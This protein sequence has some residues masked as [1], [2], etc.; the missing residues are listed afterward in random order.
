MTILHFFTGCAA[1]AGLVLGLALPA[2]GQTVAITGGR[3]YPVARPP[4]DGATV[5]IV[6]G[7]ITAVGKA[8]TP[9]AGARVIDAKGR[10]VTPGLINGATRLGLIEVGSVPS[11]NDATPRGDHG[12]AAAFRAWD[13][14]NPDSAMWVP[15]ASEGIT[16]VVSLPSGRFI[17]GQGAVVDTGGASRA[18]QLRLGPA[19]MVANLEAPALAETQAR[20]E[21]L[22]R[23]RELLDDSRDFAARKSDYERAATRTYAAGRLQLQALQLVLS[24]KLPLLVSANRAAD[25]ENALDISQQYK[26]RL[27]ILGGAEAW[28]VAGKLAAAKVAVLTTA[29]DSIP[30]TFDTLGARQE[31]AAIL[32]KAGVS[33]AIIAD[34]GETFNVRNIR[35]HAG[36]A[37]AFGLS[38]EDALRAVT[39]APA[40]VFGVA[41]SIGTIDVGKDANLVVWDGDP[42][43]FATQAERV[44]IRGVEQLGTSRQDLLTERYKMPGKR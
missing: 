26:V 31:N 18:E 15:A 41:E 2:A 7:K 28:Q 5:V 40:E 4:I 22:M 21:L 24:G 1:S 30:S 39:L 23:L 3:V 8:V 38:W 37:V 34:E 42:F 43:E 32:R 19:V 20:G 11:T 13:G 25:I 9:P 33:V 17:S 36:N 14:L 29:L 12:V 27:A 35:Q 6:D 16:S 10:W 44:F